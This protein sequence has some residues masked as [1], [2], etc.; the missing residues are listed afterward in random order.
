MDFTHSARGR[1]LHEVTYRGALTSS[2][3]CEV[4]QPRNN[5]LKAESLVHNADF[6]HVAPSPVV[7]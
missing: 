7:Y 5:E 3:G 4:E 1:L 2:E 6:G